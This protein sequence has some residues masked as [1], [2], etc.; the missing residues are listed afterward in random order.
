[1]T[2]ID[3]ND[4]VSNHIPLL[5]NRGVTA[6]GRYY[7]SAS[8]KR[9]TP[10]EAQ[11]IGSSGM[12]LFVVFENDGDPALDGNLGM[13]HA[14]IALQQAGAI[15]QPSGSAIYFAMEHLPNGYT[16][17]DIPGVKGYFNQ[18][19]S[20]IQ[21]KFKL[22]VYSDGVICDALLSSGQCSFAWL[23]ASTSF[24]GSR[25]FY[26]S[27][28]WALAQKTPVDQNWNGLSVDI[29]EAKPAFGAFTPNQIAGT[30]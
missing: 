18:I 30:A 22:G 24:A 8:W 10:R 26:D 1:M 12:S 4:D 14:Q 17:A 13:T 5:R 3:T 6:I 27:G 25:A 15:G 2:V 20:V 28:R 23:S 7:S 29:N 19:Q 9:V 16:T 11:I 21:N